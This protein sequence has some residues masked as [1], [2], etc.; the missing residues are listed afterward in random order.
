MSAVIEERETGCQPSFETVV[1][2]GK[3]DAQI[4]F[5]DCVVEHPGMA[6]GICLSLLGTLQDDSWRNAICV[7]GCFKSTSQASQGQRI[8]SVMRMVHA[9][10]GTGTT[11]SLAR[12]DVTASSTALLPDL[13]TT[14]AL[15][16]LP[17]FPMVRSTTGHV[18]TLPPSSTL[19]GETAFHCGLMNAFSR[20]QHRNP[21][22][23][24]P[25][26][27]ESR[28]RCFLRLL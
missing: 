4:I 9:C 2:P 13:L 19:D 6:A 25:R 5:H 24:R 3:S 10:G 26:P 16:T 28:R 27:F 12:R 23:K 21:I 15:D 8:S 18:E 22:R 1:Q 14:T 17:S 11:F 7:K 20:S